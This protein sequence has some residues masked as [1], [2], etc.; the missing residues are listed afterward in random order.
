MKVEGK[1]HVTAKS[2]GRGEGY[3]L[4]P[5]LFPQQKL[6]I[7]RL[8]STTLFIFLFDYGFFYESQ[9]PQTSPPINHPF[10]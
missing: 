3:K 6:T 2:F 4:A 9:P 7:S 5:T 8:F 10:I 1:Q